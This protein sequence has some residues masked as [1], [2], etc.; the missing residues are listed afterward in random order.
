L[1]WEFSSC[2]PL[3]NWTS[4]LS[5]GFG[6]ES[7]DGCLRAGEGDLVPRFG[8]GDSRQQFQSGIYI[9]AGPVVAMIAVALADQIQ[10]LR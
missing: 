2:V 9:F 10:T 5:G 6:G 4:V 7:G 3:S 1:D 8:P